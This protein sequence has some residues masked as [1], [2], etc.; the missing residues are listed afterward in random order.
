MNKLTKLIFKRYI[1]SKQI[2]SN[3]LKENLK[4]IQLKR[5]NSLNIYMKNILYADINKDYNFAKEIS[6]LLKFDIIK[7]D[8]KSLDILLNLLIY[9]KNYSF[10]SDL[11]DH[12]IQLGGEL[13][14]NALNHHFHYIYYF[15]R[16][17]IKLI[18]EFKYYMKV[19]ISIISHISLSLIQEACK[20]IKDNNTLLYISD[21]LVDHKKD[22]D[23]LTFIPF[24]I[25]V[26]NENNR[27]SDLYYLI[28]DILPQLPQLYG[29]D[30]ILVRIII[31]S[32]F[33]AI[34]NNEEYYRK[35]CE[36]I[37]EIR[38][39]IDDSCLYKLFRK[40]VNEKE[41]DL[42]I[43][44]YDILSE[45]KKPS[46]Y[47]D[48]LYYYLIACNEKKLY[49]NIYQIHKKS[50]NSNIIPLHLL[51]GEIYAK[52]NRIVPASDHYDI[53]LQYPDFADYKNIKNSDYEN[54]LEVYAE[55]MDKRHFNEIISIII[56]NFSKV[57]SD[58]LC[59]SLILY[60]EALFDEENMKILRNKYIRK[61]ENKESFGLLEDLYKT[62]N[63][64]DLIWLLKWLKSNVN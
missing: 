35:L 43:K 29:T 30:P 12:Q 32:L 19:D 53:L 26:Y 7:L 56:K 61:L 49:D 52:Q 59:K 62:N 15:E 4:D 21:Y 8:K 11:V 6:N 37:Q 18:N 50:F 46:I 55:K 51:L 1:H 31:T 9:N 13:T 60:S 40:L 10:A 25:D 5:N 47:Q 34:Y 44:S 16:N 24:I 23:S 22:F 39:T 41:Y 27:I 42:L 28:D 58:V 63:K 3:N 38:V 20:K 33:Q 54:A 57:N 64:K 45:Y 36:K 14:Q 2:I 48:A 17:Y